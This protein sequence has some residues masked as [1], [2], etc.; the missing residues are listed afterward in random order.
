[1]STN[2]INS[3]KFLMMP[4]TTQTLYFHLIARA[5]DDGVVEAFPV[6]RL[7]G[8][9]EDELKI[10]VAKSFVTV[11]ND[12]FVSHITH[13]LEHNRIRA[14]RK[15][16]SIYKDLL[17]SEIPSVELIETKSRADRPK[18]GHG[19]SQGQPSDNQGATSGQRSIGKDRLGECSIKTNTSQKAPCVYTEEFESL[20]SVYGR[21]GNKKSSFANF[22]KLTRAQVEQIRQN[23]PA[24]LYKTKDNLQFR[25]DL[26]TY[27]NPKKEYWNDVVFVEVQQDD[28][29]YA[30]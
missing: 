6:M 12:D 1:M 9:S 16:D 7:V 22:Q 2:I 15:V 4:Q 18:C 17:L 10:L 5:D 27:L 19:T 29:A 30:I 20:W 11:L 21:K 3:A 28:S 8:S 14:D 26:Q 25:K 13:W 23:L 24:Y